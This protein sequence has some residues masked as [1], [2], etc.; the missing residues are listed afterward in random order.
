[1]LAAWETSPSKGDLAEGDP[2]RKLVVQVLDAFS[3]AAVSPV[4]P[5]AAT[6]NRYQEFRAFPDGSTAYASRGSAA[7]KLKIVRVLPCE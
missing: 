4:I 2:S 7:S 3:G 6:G 5:V 1:M